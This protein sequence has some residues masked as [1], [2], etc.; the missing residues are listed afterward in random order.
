VFSPPQAD[1]MAS[2]HDPGGHFHQ[3][4]SAAIKG[5]SH[6]PLPSLQY[7]FP[8]LIQIKAELVTNVT[9]H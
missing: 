4:Y 6:A 5:I 3:P 9:I 7:V 8:F 2:L 1:L